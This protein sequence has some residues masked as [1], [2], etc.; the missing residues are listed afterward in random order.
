MNKI[1]LL[2]C[3]IP[4]TSFAADCAET[5]SEA[6]TTET[7]VLKTDVPAHLKGATITVRTA[8]G[9]ESTVPAEKFKVV[10]RMQQYVVTKT[11][12]ETMKTCGPNKNRLSVLG[13]NGSK[14]G[15]VSSTNGKTVEVE[16]KVGFVGGAQY[17]RMLNDTISLGVQGQTNKTCSLLIGIDF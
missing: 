12:Q 7:L 8:D 11:K 17:Q 10:P 13:G 3:L 2:L 16:S 4:M 14:S 5:T 1:L 6:V 9:R 15:L